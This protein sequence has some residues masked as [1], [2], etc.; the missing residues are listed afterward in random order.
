MKYVIVQKRLRESDAEV[1]NPGLDPGVLVGK[2]FF[3][4]MLC[5]WNYYILSNI[6]HCLVRKSR[7]MYYLFH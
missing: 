4:I 5:I 1:W 7:T 6:D 2:L 3:Q